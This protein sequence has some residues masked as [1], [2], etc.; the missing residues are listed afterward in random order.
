MTIWTLST[1]N[2]GQGVN[3]LSGDRT[4]VQ[5]RPREVTTACMMYRPTGQS[6][7]VSA[8]RVAKNRLEISFTHHLPA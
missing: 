2:E 3:T 8:H 5:E 7:V 1:P 6:E 4:R